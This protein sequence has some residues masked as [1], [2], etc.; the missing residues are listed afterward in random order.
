MGV[1]SGYGDG[2]NTVYFT[3]DD[4]SENANRLAAVVVWRSDWPPS[5][6]P[7]RGVLQTMRDLVKKPGTKFHLG[8]SAGSWS[9]SS[10]PNGERDTRYNRE[11]RV[12]RVLDREYALPEPGRT[13]V[14]L[15]D[16]R[17]QAGETPSVR[18]RVIATPAPTPHVDRSLDPDTRA[19]RMVDKSRKEMSAWSSAL[20]S[21]DVV[22]TFL[23]D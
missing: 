16:E 18:V 13:L 14:I 17:G 20:E 4:A 1:T 19:A 7:R 6:S 8:R 11:R 21:D 15:I 2:V 5:R 12:V 10:G 3:D 23:A 9:G 22:R